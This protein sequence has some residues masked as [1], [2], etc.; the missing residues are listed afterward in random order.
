MHVVTHL[1]AGWA[2]ADRTG[3]DQR[4]SSIVAWSCVVPDLDGAG[5]VIDAANRLLGRAVTDY[6]ET[7]HHYL[8][9]GLPAAV[10][11]GVIAY[12]L[13][14]RKLKTAAFA[15]ITFHLHLLMDLAGSRGSSPVDIW[16]IN[17]L[18]PVADVL[19]ISWDG[20]WPLTSWQNTTL[21]LLLLA[22]CL[23]RSIRKGYSPVGLI[24]RRAD[25]H[26]IKTLQSRFGGIVT[27]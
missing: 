8:G 9:H 11:T 24:S 20:Q 6:Y 26:V 22:Y 1:L 2:V 14:S 17:Y 12:L 10:V 4:D 13:A 18:A 5:M 7:W 27:D 16:S 21:T 3:L 23:Y 19:E 15:F 25:R